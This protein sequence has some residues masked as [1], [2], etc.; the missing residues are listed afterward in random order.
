MALH[1]VPG[2]FKLAAVLVGPLGHHALGSWGQQALRDSE[3][4]DFH[5]GL[6]VAVL[7][8]EVRRPVVPVE[9]P[10]HDP[11]EAA[12]LRHPQHPAVPG[13]VPRASCR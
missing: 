3:L 1:A 13:T 11:V 6:A 2:L 8:V 7:D 4:V 10:D 5:D 12:D 9:H